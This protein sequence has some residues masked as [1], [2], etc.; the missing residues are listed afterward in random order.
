MLRIDFSPFA[1]RSIKEQHARRAAKINAID[2]VLRRFTLTERSAETIATFDDPRLIP[3]SD[4]N[5]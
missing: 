1:T 3:T 4:S 2:L 5:P